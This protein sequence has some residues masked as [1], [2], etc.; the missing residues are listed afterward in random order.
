MR[1]GDQ[2]EPGPPLG[3]PVSRAREEHAPD[4]DDRPDGDAD[5]SEYTTAGHRADPA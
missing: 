4:V 3:Q 1:H 2:A 5:S